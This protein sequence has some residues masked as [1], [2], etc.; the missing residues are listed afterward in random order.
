M[1]QLPQILTKCMRMHAS[2]LKRKAI[3][4]MD[5]ILE[6]TIIICVLHSFAKK[7]CSADHDIPYMAIMVWEAHM[8]KC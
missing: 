8:P 5:W 6:L 2:L 3:S 4:I 1:T 7:Q